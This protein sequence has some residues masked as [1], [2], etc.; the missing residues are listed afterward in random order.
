MP[1]LGKDKKII[2]HFDPPSVHCELDLNVSKKIRSSILA[3]HQY[4]KCI[5]SQDSAGIRLSFG[6]CGRL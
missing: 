3:F 4:I 6:I 1:A 5:D 2:Y